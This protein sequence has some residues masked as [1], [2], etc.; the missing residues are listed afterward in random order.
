[1]PASD[2]GTLLGRATLVLTTVE[3]AGCLNQAELARRS[4]LPKPTARRIAEQL[5]A[6]GLLTRT[7]EGYELG[8]QL[9]A[10]GTSAAARHR[11]RAVAVPQ[12]QDLLARS[13]E[14]VFVLSVARDLSLVTTHVAYGHGRAEA[15]ERSGGF[16]RSSPPTSEALLTAAG[17]AAYAGR[18][19]LI[20]ALLAAGVR[21][22]TRYS[23]PTRRALTAVLAASRDDGTT[24][25]RDEHTLGWSCIAAAVH[26]PSG[27]V[28]EVVGVVGRSGTWRPERLAGPLARASE[29]LAATFAPGLTATA[30]PGPLPSTVH[31]LNPSR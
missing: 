5:A 31:S 27:R 14:T 10:L 12:V 29:Q 17:R 8:P 28:V 9:V 26:D 20:E 7:P 3:A 18:P 30:A 24:I 13:G 15:V 19:E 4:G 22:R 23:S 6:R 2:D 1:M 21:R 11:H 25:E 16:P